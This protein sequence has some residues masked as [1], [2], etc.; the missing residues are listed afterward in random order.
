MDATPNTVMPKIRI[1]DEIVQLERPTGGQLLGLAMVNNGGFSE[2]DQA[3]LMIAAIVK[4]IPATHRK[5]FV[6]LYVS[7]GHTAADLIETFKMIAGTSGVD[8]AE[9]ANRE[10]RRAAVKKTAAK[11]TARKAPV[12]R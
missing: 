3:E 10:Q 2:E 11:K 1:G 9:P 12:K 4:L 6:S 5:A 8:V 7:G